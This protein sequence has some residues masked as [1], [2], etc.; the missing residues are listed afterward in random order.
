L[1]ITGSNTFNDITN[2]Y[3]STGATTITFTAGTTT[4]VSNFTASGEAGRL[5][6]LNTDTGA[7]ATLS[8]TSG[9]VSVSYCSI[10]NSAAIG[11]AIWQSLTSNGNID[12]GGNSG[13]V[14]GSTGNM[15]LMFS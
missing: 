4:T 3:K 10:Y 12:N 8:D 13:W 2:T 15:F 11:G 7:V 1:T 6:T 14:F 9:T 5:L